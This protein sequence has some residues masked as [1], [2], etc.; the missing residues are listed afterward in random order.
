MATRTKRTGR[1]RKFPQLYDSAWMLAHSAETP[2]AIAQQLGCSISAA[3]HAFSRH[4]IVPP[5]PVKIPAQAPAPSPEVA[6]PSPL[7]DV[8]DPLEGLY[9]LAD[10]MR[11]I[12]RQLGEVSEKLRSVDAHLAA[13]NPAALKEDLES[14]RETLRR[15]FA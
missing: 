2:E 3:A 11:D 14:I 15:R 12:G 8:I 9:Y 6:T 10:E 5:K 7:Q 13:L 1:P 4:G